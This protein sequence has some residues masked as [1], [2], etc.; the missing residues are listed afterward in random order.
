M[1]HALRC[2]MQPAGDKMTDPVRRGI[3]QMVTAMLNQ[4]DD[5]CRVIAAACVGL[6]CKFLPDDETEEIARQNILGNI[7]F[8]FYK[9]IIVILIILNRICISQTK[10]G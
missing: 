4:S 8:S 7:T 1:L 5:A 10:F 2:I 3:V 6:L 9:S